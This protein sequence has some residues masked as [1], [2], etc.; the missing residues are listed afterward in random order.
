VYGTKL[1]WVPTRGAR[2]ENAHIY[3][4]GQP[5]LYALH[6]GGDGA[7]NVFHAAPTRVLRQR[8]I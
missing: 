8:S 6:H 4:L 5:A 1:I 7:T 2:R 3:S